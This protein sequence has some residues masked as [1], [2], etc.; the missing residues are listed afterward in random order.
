MRRPL[1]KIGNTQYDQYCHIDKYEKFWVMYYLE[2]L[3]FDFS[4]QAF[5]FKG[6]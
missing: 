6:F 5:T 1:G 2:M 3:T 4:R